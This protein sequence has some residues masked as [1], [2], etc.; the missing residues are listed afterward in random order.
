MDSARLGFLVFKFWGISA[1]KELSLVIE[2]SGQMKGPL[3][4]RAVP[5]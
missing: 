2:K 3:M 4:A 1:W 5:F